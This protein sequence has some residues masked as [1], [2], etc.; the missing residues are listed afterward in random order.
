MRTAA[1][2]YR[3]LMTT[4]AARARRLGA[5][6]PEGAA[7]EAVKRSLANPLSRAAVNYYFSD[8]ASSPEPI[9]DW[10]LLQLMGWLH[11]VLR[12]VVLEERPRAA[13]EHTTLDGQMPDVADAAAGPLEQIM[14][15]ERD[16]IVQTALSALSA[17]HRAAV[18]LRFKGEKYSAIATQLGVNENTV[19]TWVRRGARALIE[20]VRQQVADPPVGSTLARG[21]KANSNG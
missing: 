20:R 10:S 4:L 14:D 6:D 19:A 18:L 2:E 15:A 13:R 9:P 21:T 16:A 7:Q 17:D 12:F 11:G 1:T 5:N 3:K 8:P